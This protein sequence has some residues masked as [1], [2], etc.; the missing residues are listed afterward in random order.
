VAEVRAMIEHKGY[1]PVWKDW[2]R[3]G[4]AQTV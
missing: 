1:K 4:V 3:F 2:E